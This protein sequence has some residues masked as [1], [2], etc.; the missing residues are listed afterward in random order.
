MKIRVLGCY[1]GELHEGM[2]HDHSASRNTCGFLINDTLMVDAGTISASLSLSDLV[3]LRHVLLS[4]I[5]LD[6]VKGLPFLADNLFGMISEPIQILA[7]QPVLDSLHAHVFNDHVW[8]DFTKLPSTKDPTFT[9]VPLKADVPHPV[10]DFM[11]TSVEVNHIVPAVGFL[12]SQGGSSILYSGDTGETEKI[13][14]VAANTPSLKAVFIETSFPDHQKD[15]ALVSG[16]LT[17]RLLA[18]EFRKIGKPT[19]PLYIYHMKPRY[20]NEIKEDFRKLKM[21]HVTLLEDGAVLT[22]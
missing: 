13:W 22:I 16:H 6:H 9:L 5:H 4:H 1:G 19:I 18:Q 7:T 14:E 17:P 15:L 3:K 20:L 2:A 8:P 21:H 11:V 10:G 12:I